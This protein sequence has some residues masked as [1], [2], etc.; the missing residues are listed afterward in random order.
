[1]TSLPPWEELPE[2]PRPP[3]T[4]S[5]VRLSAPLPPASVPPRMDNSEP[6]MSS[7]AAPVTNAL[8]VSA[9]PPVSVQ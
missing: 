2:P 8:P 5:S 1:M 4:G 7:A 6:I 3:G 9:A